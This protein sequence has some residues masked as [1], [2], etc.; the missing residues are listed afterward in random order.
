MNRSMNDAR[1][2]KAAIVS[3]MLDSRNREDI[4][5]LLVPALINALE[6]IHDLENKLERLQQEVTETRLHHNLV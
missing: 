4:E 3:V 5:P 6:K 1:Y 2:G